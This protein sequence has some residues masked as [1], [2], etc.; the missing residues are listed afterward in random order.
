[1]TMRPVK[2]ENALRTANVLLVP[3]V[4]AV[5]TRTLTALA[6]ARV[7]PNTAALGEPAAALMWEKELKLGLDIAPATA[8][9]VLA[10][11]AVGEAG[12]PGR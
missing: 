11:G 1:M 6:R 9:V 2:M 5:I 4:M 8:P 10:V 7:R 12:A 3:A